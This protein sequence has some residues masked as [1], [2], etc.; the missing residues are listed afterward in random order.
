M[1][2]REFMNII[3]DGTNM[4]FD[5][6]AEKT[7][8]DIARETINAVNEMGKET[9]ELEIRKPVIYM[10]IIEVLQ[11]QIEEDSG[12]LQVDDGTGH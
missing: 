5:A 8:R 2:D 9:K 7:A 1:D 4:I 12:K 10:K 11:K 3:R 6:L